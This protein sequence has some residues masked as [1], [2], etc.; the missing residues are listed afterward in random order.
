MKVVEGVSA[1][2]PFST[3]KRPNVAPSSG[4]SLSESIFEISIVYFESRPRSD[5]GAEN[6][7]YPY[8]AGPSAVDAISAP[9]RCGFPPLPAVVLLKSA[10]GAKIVPL[11]HA[12]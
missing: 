2:V 5:I 9:E 11:K 6:G 3:G 1:T 8:S 7:L 10:D 12:L 4:F